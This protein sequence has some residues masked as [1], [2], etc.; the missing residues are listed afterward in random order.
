MVH[1]SFLECILHTIFTF[2]G[3]SLMFHFFGAYLNNSLHLQS[4]CFQMVQFVR[5]QMY[6]VDLYFLYPETK[7][8]GYL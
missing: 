7:V 2:F 1:Q 8:L 3:S 4:K 6:G 5:K